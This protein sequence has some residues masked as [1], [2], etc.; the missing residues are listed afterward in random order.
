L[1][2]DYPYLIEV[3]GSATEGKT[4]FCFL[5]YQAPDKKN[6]IGLLE[7][8]GLRCVTRAELI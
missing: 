2:E 8:D 5:V 7:V 6:E 3:F 1:C 4:R